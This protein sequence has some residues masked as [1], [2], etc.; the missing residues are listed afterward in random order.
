[1]PQ[2]YPFATK[3]PLVR[4]RAGKP[5]KKTKDLTMGQ[6]VSSP[7]TYLLEEKETKYSGVGE[8]FT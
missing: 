7:N 2:E 8:L 3:T 4:L 6:G 1:V 5:E